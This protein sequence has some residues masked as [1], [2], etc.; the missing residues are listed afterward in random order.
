MAR[1]DKDALAGDKA[2]K[3]QR[4]WGKVVD[5][6]ETDGKTAAAKSVTNGGG[7]GD[8]PEVLRGRVDDAAAA[9][10]GRERE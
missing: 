10:K 5:R 4:Q 1:R 7:R 9:R 6:L 8:S 3:N 2:L